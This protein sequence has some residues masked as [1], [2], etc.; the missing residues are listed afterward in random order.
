M[1]LIRKGNKIEIPSLKNFR[2]L[3][4]DEF[5]HLGSQKITIKGNSKAELSIFAVSDKHKAIKKYFLVQI[6]EFLPNNDFK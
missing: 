3:I 4:S 6:E 5:K 1:K 2:F